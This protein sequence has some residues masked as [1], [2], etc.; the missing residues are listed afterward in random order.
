MSKQEKK[1]F[2]VTLPKADGKLA[3]LVG[4]ADVQKVGGTMASDAHAA[5]TRYM[6]RVY[7]NNANLAL[8]I[9]GQ[10]TSGVEKFAFE[11][12]EIASGKRLANSEIVASGE[13]CSADEA[14]QAEEVFVSCAIGGFYHAGETT[15]LGHARKILAEFDRI[16]AIAETSD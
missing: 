5:V 11:V 6:H 12:P 2:I 4:Y 7:S 3:E 15:Y 14:K 1:R 16:V 8:N 10:G 13:R 9:L